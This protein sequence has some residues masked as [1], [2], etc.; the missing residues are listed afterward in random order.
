MI[1]SEIITVVSILFFAILLFITEKLPMDLVAI[2]VLVSLALSGL[3]TPAEALSGFSNT[4]VITVWAVLILSGAL[5]RTGIA[6]KIG[7]QVLKLSGNS[8]IRLLFFIMLA[9]GLLSGFMNSIGVASLFLPVVL[10]IARSTKIPP[11]RLLMPLAF[12]SLLG[13]L[14]TLIGTPPNLLVS[15]ALRQAGLEPFRMFDF[16]PIGLILMAAGILFMIL[17]G[18]RLLPDRDIARATLGRAS[19]D[20]MDLYDIRD[21]MVILQMPKDSI[22]VGKTLAQSRLGS[23]LG[24]NVIAILRSGSIKLAPNADTVL[25]HGDRLLVEGRLDQL[26]ELHGRKHLVL[27]NASFSIEGMVST[28]INFVEVQLQADSN[29]VGKTLRDVNFRNIYSLIVLAIH[30]NARILRTNI[31]TIPLGVGD[32]LL[33]QG[34]E[35]QI[36]ALSGLP[37]LIITKPKGFEI[38]QLEDRLMVV[39]IPPDSFLVGKTLIESR[40]GDAFGLGVMGIVRGG[41][42]I[43]MP[44][45]SERLLAEDTLLVKGRKEDLQ[46]VEG[47]QYLEI[48]KSSPPDLDELVSDEI[49]VVEMVLSPHTTLIGKTLRELNFREKFGL[50]VLAIWREG[51]AYRSN[52]RDISLRFGDAFLLYGQR[53]KLRFLGNEQD[54]LV[55]SGDAQQ[56]QRTDKALI[57]VLIMIG[58]LASVILGLTNIAIAA[59]TGVALMVLSGCVTMEEAYRY[60]ELKAIFLIAGML[61][62]GIALERTGAAN[63]VAEGMV[64]AFG[65]LGP[66]AITAGLFILAALASQVMPNPAVVVLLAPVALNTAR[67][68]GTSPYPL[69]MALAISASAAFLSPV[70]HA[71]NVLV[72]GPGGYR[73][74]DYTRVGLP[75]TLVVLVI[76]LLLLPFF[77]P[78]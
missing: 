68:M 45:A 16:T 24:L 40:L 65:S 39:A 4:A 1:S 22:L 62:L 77:W 8:Q 74:S 27:E 42:T 71:A 55:L 26:S 70:G 63:L 18:R 10:D 46:T 64:A 3:I 41:E 38:Y 44:D 43:L 30:R 13:G 58:V 20:Y 48:D 76:T 67:D 75:L 23:V 25:Q 7:N 73:F 50:S 36:N 32:T 5:S 52:L 12:A 14:V 49:G 6:T 57:A 31:E 17:V 66:L 47:L 59:V 11:S 15:D 51:R 61:P 21:R 69:M 56:A 34:H 60:I 37:G 19:Q 35:A 29:L 9:A 54:F 72:M 28:D 53:E 78:Y 2:L 33:V